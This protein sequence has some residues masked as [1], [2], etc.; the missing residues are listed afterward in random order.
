MDRETSTSYDVLERM[1]LDESAEPTSLPLSLLQYITTHFSLDN[2]IGRGGFAVV[3][4]VA[5]V[6]LIS[7]S[8]PNHSRYRHETNIIRYELFQITYIH[9]PVLVNNGCCHCREW[10]G[11]VWSP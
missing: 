3:Y 7:F 11:K 4:K 9:D 2:E 5:Q 10:L 6:D 1:L 8:N